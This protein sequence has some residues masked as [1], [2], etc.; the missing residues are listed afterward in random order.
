MTRLLVVEDQPNDLRNATEVA[1][2][3]GFTSVDARASAMAAKI[4][5]EKGLEGEHVL[6]DAIVLDLDLGYESGFELMRFWHG[7]PQLAGIPLIVW[8]VMGEEQ[9]EICGLFK[10][11]AYVQKSD[12]VR[13]LKEALEGLE[14]KVS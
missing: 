4:Y 13:P 6:P 11:S 5:L 7:K 8:T 9:R 10:V 1:R 3:L 14:R 12:D 2:S